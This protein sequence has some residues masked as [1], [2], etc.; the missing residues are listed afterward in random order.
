M[1]TPNSTSD[2][3][4]L[5]T[6]FSTS[7]R[8]VADLFIVTLWVVFLTL[9]FLGTAWPR[10]AFYALLLAGIAVYVTITAAWGDR[11]GTD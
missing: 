2:G 3:G 7:V 10:W 1:S 11:T 6:L 4:S 9:L 8:I 5:S